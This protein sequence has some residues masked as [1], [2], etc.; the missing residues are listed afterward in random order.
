MPRWTQSHKAVQRFR[1]V[2]STMPSGLPPLSRSHTIPVTPRV[3]PSSCKRDLTGGRS[4]QLMPTSSDNS[5]T[6][7]PSSWR[8]QG[9]ASMTRTGACGPHAAS[10]ARWGRIPVWLSYPRT[11]TSTA[12]PKDRYNPQRLSQIAW[13]STRTPR[14]RAHGNPLRSRGRGRR[15]KVRAC[16]RP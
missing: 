15:S 3:T 10:T 13:R 11:C 5:R 9:S 12:P 2:P 16:A 14:S 7:T 6:T 1:E 8:P 4:T